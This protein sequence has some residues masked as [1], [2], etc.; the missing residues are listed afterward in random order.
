[1][2]DENDS[3]FLVYSYSST[4]LSASSQRLSLNPKGRERRKGKGFR[5]RGK[6]KRGEGGE[7]SKKYLVTRI[8]ISAFDSPI[9]FRL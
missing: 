1:M 7:K 2:A 4:L 9:S 3:V 5:K 6:E 8:R